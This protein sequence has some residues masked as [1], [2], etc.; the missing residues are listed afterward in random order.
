MSK[1]PLSGKLGL[2]GIAIGLVASLVTA[3][4]QAVSLKETKDYYDAMGI[5]E[6]PPM[7]GYSD[8]EDEEE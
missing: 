6:L 5:P 7:S 1:I 8:D 3:A 4:G 2:A